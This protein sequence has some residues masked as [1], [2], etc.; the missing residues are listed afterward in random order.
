M[1]TIKMF[2]L[3]ALMLTCVALVKYMNMNIWMYVLFLVVGFI[4]SGEK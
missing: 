2:A 4:A 1:R 3:V